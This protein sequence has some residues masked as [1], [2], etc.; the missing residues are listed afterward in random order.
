M[1]E[2]KR[3]PRVL[4]IYRVMIP[5]LLLCGHSQ[6][7]HLRGAGAAEYRCVQEQ[8]ITKEDLD[9]ADVVLLGR[10]DSWFELRLAKALRRNGKYLAYIIDDDLLHVPADMTSAPYYGLPAIKR[11]ISALIAL[12]D[13]VI[14]PSPRLLARYAAGKSGFL[15]EEPALA[16]AEFTPHAAGAPITIG[17]A[18][19]LDRTQDIERILR[20]VL[21]RIQ[22]EYGARVRFA[23]FG[24]APAFARELNAQVLPFVPSYADYLKQLCACGWDIGLGP[25]PQSDFHACK[26]YIKFIEYA[27]AGMAGVFSVAPPYDRLRAMGAPAQLC[28][29]AAESW[30]AALKTWLEDPAALERARRAAFDYAAQHFTCARAAE[31]LLPL[32]NEAMATQSA[33]PQ[34]RGGYRLRLNK[35]LNLAHHGVNYVRMYGWSAP[36][37]L[38]LR[39]MKKR[40]P[41]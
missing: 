9:W 15:L 40:T 31:G 37:R 10:L 25:M 26:H 19:S 13:A 23:F 7:E 24:A 27:A 35:A 39:V 29:N 4:M 22:Q 14:S 1:M 36:R 5:S 6:M 38:A 16:Q 41:N 12:S 32:L 21:P 20:G 17:F 30:Y 8:R 28:G 2:N 3:L 18:G 34:R 33:R 11:Q